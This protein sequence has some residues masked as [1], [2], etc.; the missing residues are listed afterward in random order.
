[1][2]QQNLNSSQ[3]EVFQLSGHINASNVEDCQQ[4]LVDALSSSTC[5][6]FV[7][8]MQQVESLDSAG[9]MAF[10]AALNYAQEQGKTFTLVNVS[11]ALRIIFEL[12][13]L[14]QVF[15]IDEVKPDLE[16]IAA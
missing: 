5:N 2:I 14:D 16:L 8:D 15:T 10:V 7:V 9:L 13:Q 1:M 12:T 11:D 4:S 6:T 3:V